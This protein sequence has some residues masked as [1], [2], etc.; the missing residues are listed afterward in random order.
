MVWPFLALLVTVSTCTTWFLP[1]LPL[2][3]VMNVGVPPAYREKCALCFP[4][5]FLT[6][7]SSFRLSAENYTCGV[8][9][10]ELTVSLV[11]TGR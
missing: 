2:V 4:G 5:I 1:F 10:I 7:Y 9:F 6:R 8:S 11:T 3:L